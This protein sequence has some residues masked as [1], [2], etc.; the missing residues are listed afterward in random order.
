[1]PFK[2]TRLSI[3]EIIL[4]EPKVFRDDRGSFVE[5]YKYSDFAAYGIT[6]SF[7]QDNHSTS[8]KGVLS[9]SIIR[10]IQRPRVN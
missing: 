10:Q 7:V 1:M 6:E 3:P 4:I 8:V 2:F 5:T 9:D